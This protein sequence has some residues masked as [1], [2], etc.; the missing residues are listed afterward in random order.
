M[1]KRDTCTTLLHI[2]LA[3]PPQI[4]AVHGQIE[5]ASGFIAGR[6]S[7]VESE[8]SRLTMEGRILIAT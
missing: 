8:D 1:A 6:L 2:N 7:S 4:Y 3:T 5:K